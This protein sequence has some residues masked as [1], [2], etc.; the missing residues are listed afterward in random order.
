MQMMMKQVKQ[1]CEELWSQPLNKMDVYLDHVP[2]SL[3][4]ITYFC[5][6]LLI[7]HKLILQNQKVYN[8][9]KLIN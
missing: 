4:H 5:F 3:R 2:L 9:P 8:K 7:N 6:Y 1:R